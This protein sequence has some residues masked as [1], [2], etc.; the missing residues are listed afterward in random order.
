MER[1][2]KRKVSEEGV[3]DALENPDEI[4]YDTQTGYFVVIRKRNSKW[5]LVI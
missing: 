3:R 4:F 2:R 5:L 1:I